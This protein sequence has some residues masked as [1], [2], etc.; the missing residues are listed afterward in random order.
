MLEMGVMHRLEMQ[1]V[2]ME[3][4]VE[5]VDP[6]DQLIPVCPLQRFTYIRLADDQ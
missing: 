4:L 1:L 3:V 6:V 2:G 5:E